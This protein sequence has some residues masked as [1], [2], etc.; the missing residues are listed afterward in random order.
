MKE[1]REVGVHGVY[2]PA[3]LSYCL[4]PLTMVQFRKK[5]QL[6]RIQHGRLRFSGIINLGTPMVPYFLWNRLDWTSLLLQLR[7]RAPTRC[8]RERS[9]TEGKSAFVTA[10]PL[11]VP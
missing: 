2:T 5:H 6:G 4:T 11:V 3:G 8:A 10:G 1:L 7:K 9:E